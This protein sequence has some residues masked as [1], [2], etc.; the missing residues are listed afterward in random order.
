MIARSLILDIL[1][2]FSKPAPYVQILNGHMVSRFHDNI[3]DGK[4]FEKQ[5]EDLHKYCDFVNFETA[6]ELIKK[7]IKVKKSTVAFSFDDGWRDCY[8]QIAPQLDKYGVNAAFFINP[9]FIDA[10]ER[11]DKESSERLVDSSATSA[12][13]PECILV[14]AGSIHPQQ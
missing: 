7:G 8:T 3:E 1:G 5:L 10:G 11:S 6:V 2:L 4:I 9:N 14:T 12:L 13:L